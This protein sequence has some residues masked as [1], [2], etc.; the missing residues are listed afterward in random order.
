MPPFSKLRKSTRGRLAIDPLRVFHDVARAIV[1]TLDLDS[2]LGTIM[3][4][5]AQLYQPEQWSLMMIDEKRG[6]LFYAIAG[7]ADSERMR[8]I[9]IPLGTGVAGWVAD[10]DRVLI[11]AESDG[12]ERY[13][14]YVRDHG[15][16]PRSIIAIP[17]RSRERTLGVMQLI[18]T[19]AQDLGDD[20]I[21]LLYAI[22]DYA[23]IA[24]DNARAVARIHELT[25]TDEYTGLYNAR[26]LYRT[27]EAEVHRSRDA[28]ECVSLVFLD[29]DHFKTV[30]DTHGHLVGSALLA[31]VAD[32]IKQSLRPGDMAF[33]YGGDEFVML[34]PATDK[35]EAMHLSRTL[36]QTI[37]RTRYGIADGLS[38]SIKASLGVATYPDDGL[39][40]HEMIRSS[41]KAMYS[42]KQSTRNDVL[43]A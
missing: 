38:L 26:H 32:T 12:D 36:L 33:R 6:D 16:R 5:T 43:S 28:N 18:N 4:E 15:T 21:V 3:H 42:V 10:V 37:R 25:I 34:Y 19:G 30:N 13:A 22:C 41:D 17:L 23:A 31:E 7:G 1:S 11:I 9:R 40:M 24:I 20:A 2:V 27:L 14:Q 29:I 8:D 39:D 35:Q